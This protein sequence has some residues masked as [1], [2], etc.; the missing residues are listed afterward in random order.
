MWYGI[1][2]LFLGACFVILIITLA[3]TTVNLKKLWQW[4]VVS[5]PAVVAA[6]AGTVALLIAKKGET[7]SQGGKG[8]TNIPTPV[9]AHDL[10][11]G[12]AGFN[13]SRCGENNSQIIDE[14]ER[15][16]TDPGHA[17]KPD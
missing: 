16:T 7:D 13:Q 8:E 6:I 14:I 15:N 10:E 11:S 12:S 5:I 3:L 17:K 9:T 2:F 1:I 4:I